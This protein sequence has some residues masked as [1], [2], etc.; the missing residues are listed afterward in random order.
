MV[1]VALLSKVMPSQ[2]GLAA[3]LPSRTTESLRCIELCCRRRRRRWRWA[4]AA[5]GAEQR[6]ERER[7]GG[8]ALRKGG[9]QVGVDKE[10]A[11]DEHE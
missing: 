6:H 10:E 2:L 8:R 9:R 5:V 4:V 11:H 3:H 1:R 7:A